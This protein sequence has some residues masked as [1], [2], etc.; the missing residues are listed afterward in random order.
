MRRTRTSAIVGGDKKWYLAAGVGWGEDG[1]LQ[2][3]HNALYV[4]KEIS[5]VMKLKNRH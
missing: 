1:L 2:Y 4:R 5:K 3:D